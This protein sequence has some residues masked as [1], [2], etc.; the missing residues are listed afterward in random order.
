MIQ[1]MS[2]HVPGIFSGGSLTGLGVL[3]GIGFMA[4]FVALNWFVDPAFHLDQRGAH[5]REIRRAAITIIALFV[6]GFHGSN[7]SSHGGFAPYGWAPAAGSRSWRR[8][9][10]SGLI[11]YVLPSVSA[12]MFARSG[13]YP[14]GAPRWMSTLAPVAFVLATL[15]IYRAG[16]RELR[17]A[18]PIL[19]IGVFVYAYQHWRAGAPWCDAR[20]GLWLVAYL[21]LVLLM[22]GIGSADFQGTNSL[23][24]PWDSVIV[25]VIAL[26]AWLAGIRAGRQ[27]LARSPATEGERRPGRSQR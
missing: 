22:S 8:R 18:L 5:R 21:A 20:I 15:I 23:P 1:Y 7:F 19:L 14:G 16:R 3:L 4:V 10:S 9:A 25:A 13:T 24:A 17:I 6:S 27:H 11:A 26:A 2:K 12:V